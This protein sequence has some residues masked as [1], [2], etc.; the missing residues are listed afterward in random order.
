MHKID[1][2]KAE[3]GRVSSK[4]SSFKNIYFLMGTQWLMVPPEDY[5]FKVGSKCEFRFKGIDAPFNILGMPVFRDYYV[6]HNY[7]GDEA[8]MAFS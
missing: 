2:Y 6:T 8:T 3:N 7:G 1:E 4:C 5:Y